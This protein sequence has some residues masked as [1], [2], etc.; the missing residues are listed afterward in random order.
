MIRESM[1]QSAHALAGT[2][3]NNFANVYER[4]G[5]S[6]KVLSGEEAQQYWKDIATLRIQM[7]REFPYLYEGSYEYEKDYLDIYFRSSASVILLFFAGDKVV[8]FSSAIPL[9]EEMDEIKS[10]FLAHNIDASKYL[11]VGEFMLKPEY[12]Q[13]ISLGLS[14]A[15]FY[16]D[17]A[18]GF[19]REK[20]VFMTVQRPDNH[21]A[22]PSDYRSLEPL[23]CRRSFKKREDLHIHITWEQIDTHREENNVL[24]IWEK[25]LK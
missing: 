1:K 6:V 9:K 18:R 7:F 24:D 8:G 20:L 3:V 23:W 12:R 11:Y 10:P 19:G 4:T 13:G 2:S 5:I 17:Y 15:Q 22:R 14:V 21:A 16:E 25:D